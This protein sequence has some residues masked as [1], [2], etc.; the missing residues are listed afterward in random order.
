MGSMFSCSSCGAQYAKWTGRCT[1][2]SAWGTILE[3]ESVSHALAPTKGK[4]AA[5]GSKPAPLLSLAETSAVHA[6]RISSGISEIDRVLGGGI[7]AG[8]VTLLA[9]EPGIGK[10]TLVAQLAGGMAPAGK[11]V[12]YA[13]GEESEGQVHLRCTRLGIA[14][15]GIS[16]SNTV[17]VGS[18]LATAEKLKPALLIVDSIQT[19]YVADA[20]AFPG[21]PTAVRAAT[22]L[23]VSFAKTSGTPVLIIGQVTKEGSVAGPKTLEHLVDTVLTLEGDP[24][25]PYRTLRIAKHRFGSTEEVGL[26]EMTEKGLVA[27][28]NPS[29]RFLAERLPSPGSVVCAVMDG[30]RPFLLEVQALVEKSYFPNPVRRT[31][32]YD[33]GRLQM[34][35]A[36]ISKR[37]GVRLHDQ[38]VYV[39]IVGG[40]RVAE[41]AADLAVA[42]AVIS[43]AKNMPVPDT[44]VYF[45]EVGLGGEVRSVPFTE[46]RAK[47]AER[48]GFTSV[49]SPKTTKHL[50]E[51]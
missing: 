26:F 12:Y 25:H 49:V 35:L 51:L 48:H 30:N 11:T 16:F 33:L 21:T 43:A 23:L 36:I 28:D 14:L 34:L 31:S 27:V 6:A 44:D 42:A 38:D 2:C 24:D 1:T 39:N 18:I 45:G 8:S 13:S 29:A 7:V 17:D 15:A 22:A 47:E 37:A 41:N 5:G 40:I 46:R 19:M 4:R 50:R 10:S 32:G 9:G 3:E 20:D